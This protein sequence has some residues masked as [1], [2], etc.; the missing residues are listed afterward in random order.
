MRGPETEEG[1][2][3]RLKRCQWISVKKDNH[4]VAEFVI[5][6]VEGISRARKSRSTG[7]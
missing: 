5:K 7:T 3:S 2:R 1:N 4:D 6:R